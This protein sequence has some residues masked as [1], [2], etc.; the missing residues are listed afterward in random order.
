[1]RDKL[2]NEIMCM[3]IG[4]GIEPDSVKNKLYMILA[5]YDVECRHTEV[6]VRD[7]DS[8]KKYVRLFLINKRVA[9]R[10]QNTLRQ[11]SDTLERFF[12]NVPKSPLEITSDDIKGYLAMMEVKRGASKCYQADILRVISA[13]YT[14]MVREEYITSNPMYRVETIKIPRRRKEAFTDTEIELLRMNAEGD[15]RL[16]LVLEMLL[17]TW[18]RASELVQIK[19][20]DFRNNYEEVLIHGKGQK[21]RICYMNASA[22]LRLAKYLSRR[23]DTNI[24]LFPCL[25]Q[26]A[27]A[28]K[29]EDA[30]PARCKKAHVKMNDWWTVPE[31]IGD[32][33]ET[34]DALGTKIRKLGQKAGVEN[35]HPHRFRRTGATFALRR[36]MPIESVS[37]LLGHESIDTTQIYLDIS[38]KEVEHD[39]RKYV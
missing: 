31:L 1:M 24:Y 37:R 38:E 13:F 32:D 2:M 5:E 9:G 19:L 11:Y 6:I 17:S 35:T 29:G 18:C 4:E 23:N 30:F 22:K 21:D 34:K 25:K 33:H 10:T 20:T 8:I 26:P 28:G 36:G 16:T 14:W 3:L 27:W 7:E 39:H 12:E 15:D